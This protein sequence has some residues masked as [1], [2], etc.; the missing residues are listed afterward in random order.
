QLEHAAGIVVE[1]A[2]ERGGKLD[3]GDVDAAR[4]EKAG[5]ALEQIERG[6]ELEAGVARKRAQVGRRLVGIA[7]DGEEF[8]DQRPGF[9]RQRSLRAERCLLEKAVGDLA[10]RAPADSGDAGDR[11]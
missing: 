5:A 1:A 2:A 11:K 8:F 3:A 4:G 9:T 7:A 6:V 10:H